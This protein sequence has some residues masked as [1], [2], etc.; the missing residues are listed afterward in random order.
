MR[1]V[2]TVAVVLAAVGLGCEQQKPEPQPP[3]GKPMA[4]PEAPKPITSLPEPK[5]EP[6]TAGEGRVWPK[7][8]I[9]EPATPSGGGS[10][11][12]VKPVAEPAGGNSYVVK[13][14][15]TLWTIAKRVLGDGQRHKEIL[16]LNPG[17]NPTTMKVGQVLKMPPH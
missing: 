4:P 15:D 6:T 17:L 1:Y 9:T 13:K 14:G 11:G 7:P 8:L 16:A 2:L 12:M 5:A 3:P 10:V